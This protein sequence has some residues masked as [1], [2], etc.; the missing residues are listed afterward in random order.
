[1]QA[2]CKRQVVGSNPT[3]GSW[4]VD[5]EERYTVATCESGCEARGGSN[6][7]PSVAAAKRAHVAA[8]KAA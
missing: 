8:Y 7:S 6:P 1:M 4:K 3:G 2:F 5:R